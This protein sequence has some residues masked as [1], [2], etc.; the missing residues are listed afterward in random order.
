MRKEGVIIIKLPKKFIHLSV[1]DFQTNPK[2]NYIEICEFKTDKCF[3]V[4][5]NNE[6]MVIALNGGYYYF[7][8]LG[9]IKGGYNQKLDKPI[10]LGFTIHDKDI[11]YLG[12]INDMLL[13]NTFIF[14]G[15]KVFFCIK[16]N[17]SKAQ[18]FIKEKYPFIN[19]NDIQFHQIELGT[20]SEY[21]CDYKE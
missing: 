20:Q 12:D 3:H 8:Q 16:N 21:K 10:F 6:Y 7:N 11:V 1:I 2:L 5:N 15:H 18:A 4:A 9:Y 19:A 17:I 14:G 13:K